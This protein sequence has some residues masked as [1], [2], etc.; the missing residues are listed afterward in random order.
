MSDPLA[1]VS[2]VYGLLCYRVCFGRWSV[3]LMNRIERG[4]RHLVWWYSP[5]KFDYVPSA[6]VISDRRPFP[7]PN[8]E[9]GEDAWV[10]IVAR[11]E[12]EVKWEIRKAALETKAA[13]SDYRRSIYDD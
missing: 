4:A 10:G 1:L 3:G 8:P 7:K 5:S 11:A 13:Y 2:A 12:R 9:A 6:G